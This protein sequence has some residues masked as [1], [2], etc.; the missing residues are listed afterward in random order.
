MSSYNQR[1]CDIL[2]KCAAF[3]WLARGR[4]KRKRPKKRVTKSDKC[5]RLTRMFQSEENHLCTSDLFIAEIWA[6]KYHLQK[7][8]WANG[9]IMWHFTRS[10]QQCRQPIPSTTTPPTSPNNTA[11]P[12]PP[13]PPPLKRT[14]PLLRIRPP[15]KCSSV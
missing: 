4:C 8:E 15:G 1:L 3:S 10:V 6:Q 5:L 7:M 2:G 14:A 13:P 11:T 9:L 12:P